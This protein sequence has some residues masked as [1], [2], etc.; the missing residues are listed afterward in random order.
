MCSAKVFCSRGVKVAVRPG[1]ET[2]GVFQSERCAWCG[3][4]CV[5]WLIILEGLARA[6]SQEVEGAEF[7][8]LSGGM[9]W[10]A[11]RRN[12]DKLGIWDSVAENWEMT[13]ARCLQDKIDAVLS[14]SAESLVMGLWIVVAVVEFGILD[15]SWKATQT[16]D[17]RRAT[18]TV[19]RKST[20]EPPE[21][22]RRIVF[23][24]GC[25]PAH[26]Q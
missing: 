25:G 5:S 2:L 16:T 11:A 6:E 15:G 23:L 8:L 20:A 22:L 10:I 7:S 24:A 12:L 3:R 18:V 14:L 17:I 26:Y 13:Q 1:E 19:E 4:R 21:D 9:D